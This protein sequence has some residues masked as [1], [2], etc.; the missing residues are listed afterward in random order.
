MRCD[1]NPH[2][3]QPT[4]VYAEFSEADFRHDPA[5]PAVAYRL[6]FTSS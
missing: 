3:H 1:A 5:R 2:W 4:D 6:S